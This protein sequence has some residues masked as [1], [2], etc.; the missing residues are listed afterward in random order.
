VQRQV[1]VLRVPQPEEDGRVR[2]RVARE[3]ARHDDVV[4][5][6]EKRAEDAAEGDVDQRRVLARDVRAAVLRLLEVVF[7]Q[8]DV[9]DVE[10]AG[11]TRLEKI[12]IVMNN[13]ILNEESGCSV[14][15]LYVNLKNVSLVLNIRESNNTC[16]LCVYFLN[17][18][19]ICKHKKKRKTRLTVYKSTFK[20]VI[21]R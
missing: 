18:R 6:A 17:A 21:N 16:V 1:V 2:V 20:Q 3:V 15:Y 5:V 7:L 10:S 11:E 4:A 13:L 19:C 8:D 12:K 14:T 9:V